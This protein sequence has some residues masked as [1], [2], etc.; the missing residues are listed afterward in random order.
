[1][2]TSKSQLLIR[3]ILG[4][5]SESHGDWLGG[6]GGLS[7]ALAGITA[8]EAEQQKAQLESVTPSP[9]QRPFHH[10]R[11]H[12][13]DCQGHAWSVDLRTVLDGPFPVRSC[14]VLSGIGGLPSSPHSYRDASSLR[15]VPSDRPSAAPPPLSGRTRPD[16]PAGSDPLVRTCSIKFFLIAALQFPGRSSR[17][18]SHH[19]AGPKHETG[20]MV[21]PPWDCPGQAKYRPSAPECFLPSGGGARMA[22]AVRTSSFVLARFF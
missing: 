10:P 1:M 3:G 17:G 15:T 2:W 5:E 4:R 18:H 21:A 9:D 8:H 12:R 22:V 11:R 20:I 7:V 6:P 19:S 13:H 14:P 16:D